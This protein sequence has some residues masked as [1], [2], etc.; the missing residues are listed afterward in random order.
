MPTPPAARGWGRPLHSGGVI[1]AS[2]IA[3]GGTRLV[4][5]EGIAKHARVREVAKRARED[6]EASKEGEQSPG[7]GA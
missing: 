4:A 2:P 5:T 6:Q 1:D 7:V 3:P